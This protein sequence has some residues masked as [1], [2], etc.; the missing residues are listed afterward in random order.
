[1]TSGSRGGERNTEKRAADSRSQ[2][3]SEPGAEQTR[4]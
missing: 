2:K 3:L 4:G 1:M